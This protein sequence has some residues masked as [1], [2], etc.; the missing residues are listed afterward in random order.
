MKKILIVDDDQS[1]R[2]LLEYNF[3]QED[4]DVT[5]ADN[6]KTAYELASNDSF[7]CLILD[8]MMPKLSGI[9]VSKKLRDRQIFTPILI[10]T[11]KQDDNTMI[12]GIDQGADDYMYKPFST[13]EL[14]S[15]VNSLIRRKK[16]YSNTSEPQKDSFRYKNIFI[17]NQNKE[18]YIE[19]QEISLTKREFQLLNYLVERKN[20]PVSRAEILKKFWG[21]SDDLNYTRIVEV[22]VSKLREKIENNPKNPQYIKTKRG[23]G[24]I[25]VVDDE[26]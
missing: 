3:N 13:K 5:L 9:E 12:S 18:V 1:I 16:E 20:T 21:N 6:G 2:M 15:R 4:F 23:Y 26:N 24:Y 25:F 8:L 14:I 7:D 22:H 11:A 10:L 17:N 19:N